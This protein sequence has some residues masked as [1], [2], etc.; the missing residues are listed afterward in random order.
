METTSSH[1]I[2]NTSTGKGAGRP[3]AGSALGKRPA[4]SQDAPQDQHDAVEPVRAGARPC[5]THIAPAHCLHTHSPMAPMRTGA[6][7]RGGATV[8]STKTKFPRLA[9]RLARRRAPSRNRKQ[10]RA[11][12]SNREQPRAT[13]SNRSRLAPLAWLAPLARAP[14]LLHLPTR[15]LSIPDG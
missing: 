11:T 5:V 10:P 15:L 2:A 8:S 4:G 3:P 7:P 6:V 13:E 9:R 14:P 12:E 1:D